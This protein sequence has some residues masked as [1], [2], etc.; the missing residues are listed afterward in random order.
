[1]VALPHLNLR[2]GEGPLRCCA[3][4]SPV[5]SQGCPGVRVNERVEGVHRSPSTGKR[6]ANGQRYAASQR[7][8]LRALPQLSHS[9]R[10]IASIALARRLQLLQK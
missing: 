4:R 10:P 5:R 7:V 8:G 2:R 1:M 3:G 6:V 9:M